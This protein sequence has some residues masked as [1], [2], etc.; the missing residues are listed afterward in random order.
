[1]LH[2]PNSHYVYYSQDFRDILKRSLQ[3]MFLQYSRYVLS[4]FKYTLLCRQFYIRTF[5]LEMIS[6]E[7]KMDGWRWEWWD[8][9]DDESY[10]NKIWWPYLISNVEEWY[11]LVPLHGCSPTHEQIH[12]VSHR[13]WTPSSALIVELVEAFRCEGISI[14]C[15]R[16]LHLESSLE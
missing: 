1:M 3:N 16:I 13:G 14:C 4:N 2:C 5:E 8:I 10:D 9:Y 6:E 12:D 7:K 15:S 11:V